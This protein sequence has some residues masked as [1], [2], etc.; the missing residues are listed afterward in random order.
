V[1]VSIELD[2]E[3]AAELDARVGRR[4]RSRYIIEALRRRLEDERRWDSLT[5][6]AG[7]VPDEGHDWDTDP[8]DW[9][10]RQ[11]H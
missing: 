7:T 9:V 6:A 11:R 3:V 4:S 8:A 5:A 10:A 1:R 2:D